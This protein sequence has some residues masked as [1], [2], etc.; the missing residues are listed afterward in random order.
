[1]AAFEPE[2]HATMPEYARLY[3]VPAAVA[4]RGRGEVRLPRRVAS[5]RRGARG[6]N[7]GPAGQAGELPPGRKLVDV[8]DRRRTVGR[9][10]HGLLAAIGPGER[11]AARRPG[12]VRGALHDGAARLERRQKCGGNWPRA[13]DWRDF[14]AWRAATCATWKRPEH[15]PRGAGAGGVRLP[16]EEDHR[17][18]CRGDGRAGRGGVHR[19]NRREFGAT[20]MSAR[21]RRRSPSRWRWACAACTRSRRSRSSRSTSRP[22]RSSS[23]A[24]TRSATPSRTGSRSRSRTSC[25]PTPGPGPVR[26]GPGQPAVC[27]ARR[28]GVAAGRDH[29]RAGPRARWRRGRTRGDRPAARSAAAW[30]WPRMALALL[31]IGADQGDGDRRRPSPRAWRAGGA[32]V[33]PDLAGLPRVAGSSGSGSS[34]AVEPPGAASVVSG[35][36]ASSRC[37]HRDPRPDPARPPRRPR[38][39]R[40]AGR[41][42]PGH[43]PGHATAIRRGPAARASSSR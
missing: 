33:E 18:V 16:G 37:A 28:D 39:R 34:R 29:L 17:R 7:A 41:R 11:H 35:G 8:R 14:R 10:D 40:D 26:P 23:P 30:R 36:R 24:R 2:F 42:R 20:R 19:R 21:E 12:C 4:G 5:V 22:T 1:M 13:G 6:G 9:Y 43:R 15:R 25:R 32:R 27:P 31:E 38:Y 3:G